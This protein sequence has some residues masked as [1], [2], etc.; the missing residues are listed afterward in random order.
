MKQVM[1]FTEL[2]ELGYSRDE[3]KRYSQEEDFPGYKTAGGGKWLVYVDD[4][5]S[6]IER[7]NQR[8]GNVSETVKR[9]MRRRI[10]G[11][12]KPA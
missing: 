12:R 11:R 9:S 3:L 5:P 7:F 8:H 6:W 4:L 10:F 1:S 2:C